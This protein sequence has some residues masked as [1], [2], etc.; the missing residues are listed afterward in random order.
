MF[1]AL[2]S[3]EHTTTLKS[4]CVQPIFSFAG[5]LPQGECIFITEKSAFSQFQGLDY[6]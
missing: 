5:G 4:N 1:K 3:T 2:K 6:F